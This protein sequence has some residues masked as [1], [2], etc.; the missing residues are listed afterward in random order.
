MTCLSAV[1]CFSDV[2]HSYFQIIR[3]VANMSINSVVGSSLTCSSAVFCCNSVQ[4][5]EI[6]PSDIV[7]T[8]EDNQV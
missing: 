7:T 5:I 3:I 8:T 1:F 2:Q 4:E 6:E